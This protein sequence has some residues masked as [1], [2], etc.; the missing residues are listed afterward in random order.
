MVAE[1]NLR[2]VLRS[3]V[4]R[5]VSKDNIIIVDSLNSIKVRNIFVSFHLASLF[6]YILWHQSLG[7]L[8]LGGKFP[9]IYSFILH[10][11]PQNYIFIIISELVVN[12]VE[13]S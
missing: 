6:I 9:Y 5:S 11:F 2:G 7:L 3:E 1:K 4:D 8:P 10:F 12:I 13:M